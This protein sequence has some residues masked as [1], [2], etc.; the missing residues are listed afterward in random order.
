MILHQGKEEYY[1]CLNLLTTLQKAS[2]WFYHSCEMPQ[3]SKFEPDAPLE[4]LAVIT[5]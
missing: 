1:K 4:S 2:F 3:W 5:R